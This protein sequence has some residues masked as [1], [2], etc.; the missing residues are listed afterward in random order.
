MQI[1]PFV[2]T[3][4]N[5]VEGKKSSVQAHVHQRPL[6]DSDWLDLTL[7]EELSGVTTTTFVDE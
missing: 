3:G 2:T 7:I 4:T 1:N 6:C 5:F